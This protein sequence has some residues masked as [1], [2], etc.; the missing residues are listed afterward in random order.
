MA[1]TPEILSE[2]KGRGF[3]QNRNGETFSARLLTVNGIVSSE[4]L[5]AVAEAARRFGNGKTG[6]T[7]RMT[8]EI[9]GIKYENIEPLTAFLAKHGLETGGTGPKVRPITACKGTVCKHGLYD[10]VEFAARLHEIYYK[11]WRDVKLPH[12]FK[13]GCGGCPNNCIKPALNDMGFVGMSKGER[14]IACFIGGRYGKSWRQGDRLEGLYTEDEAIKLVKIVLDYY[15]A[16]GQ[17]KERLASMVERIGFEKVQADI[18][19]KL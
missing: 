11:G 15:L 17:P 12:K 10:T 9:W 2:L 5:E 8:F 1:L 16:N 6:L 14:P 13:I 3:L 4:T 18:L 19:A 7:S